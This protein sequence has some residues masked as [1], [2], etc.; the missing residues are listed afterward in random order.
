MKGKVVLVVDL[1]YRIGCK[2]FVV[3]DMGKVLYI[4]V[5][6]LYLFVCKYD[7]VKMKV[8]FIIDKY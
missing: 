3:D 6:Y 5:I 7:D 8:F 4:D 1:V 2:L